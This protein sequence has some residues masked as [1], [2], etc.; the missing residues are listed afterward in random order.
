MPDTVKAVVMTAPGKIEV[1]QLPYPKLRTRPLILK[2]R[3][4][5]ICGTDK[6]AYK[7]EKVLYGGTEAEQEIVYP[8]VHGHEN[9][10]VVVEID[11]ADKRLIEYHGQRTQGGRPGHDV[12]ERY[13]RPLLVLP[14][15]LRLSVLREEHHDRPV[16]SQQQAAVRGGRL[17][18]IHVRAAQ[19]LGLQSSRRVA[20]RTGVAVPKSSSSRPPST[21]PRSFRGWRPAASASLTPWP[22]R[23]PERWAACTSPR[24]A[25][26]GRARSSF[27]TNRTTK[28][29]LAKEFG[30]DVAINVRKIPHQERVKIIKDLTEGR[31]ADV[32]VETAGTAQAFVEGLDYTRRGGTYIETGSFVDTGE[33]AVNVHRHIA[34]KNVLVIGNSNHPHTGYYQAMHMMLKYRKEYPF[35]KLITH[36]FK[37]DEGK[38]AM[39]RSFDPECLKVVFTP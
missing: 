30:A 39:E 12:S 8:T 24:P 7:G 10:G 37:L 13:L 5:G 18:G 36:R 29:D 35:E 6:H 28:C 2:M 11:P 32:V 21:A 16:V 14:A 33:V 3:M 26:W 34:A 17:G 1:Q 9:V 4:S 25:C 19:G 27:S 23:G 20:G 22:F 38:K 31:G 15:H